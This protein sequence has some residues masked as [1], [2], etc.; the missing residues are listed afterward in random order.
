MAQFLVA[1]AGH[2][3]LCAAMHLARA[4]EH[5]TVVERQPEAALGHDWMD[6][7]EF[8]VLARNGF[9][10]LPESGKV[11]PW[12]NTLYGP[13]KRWPKLPPEEPVTMEACFER[14]ELL[15]GMVADCRAAG[16]EFAFGTEIMAP[17]VRGDAV[18]GLLVREGGAQKELPAGMVVDAAGGL[19]NLREKM[20]E[21]LL[22]PVR[23]KPTQLFHVWRGYLERLPGPAPQYP[24]KTILGHQGRK[25]ISWV[26]AYRDSMDVLI[27]QVGEPLARGVIDEA[28]EDLRTFEPLLGRKLLRGGCAAIPLRRPLGMMVANG[29]AAVGDSA[30]MADP[31]CGSGICSA[32]DQGKLLAEVLLEHC[33]G[34][35]RVDKL[36]SYQYRTFSE[37]P[38]ALAGFGAKDAKERAASEMLTGAVLPLRPKQVDVMFKRGI[39]SIDNID[40]P[41]VAMA[42]LGRNLDHLPLLLKLAGAA[43][44]GGKL[45]AIIGNIPKEYEARAVAAWVRAY[46]GFGGGI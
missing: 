37:K 33:K 3:G 11:Q 15:A 19:S 10:A 34:D 26:I 16:V 7:F 45:G 35:F 40:G 41:K 24:Y 4:G 30:C 5:V 22:F 6:V 32:I 18:C 23:L 9:R 17:L 42:L 43:A 1:G 12:N 25:G 31:F 20:P 38:P 2:G 13:G 44:K 29:Y 39:I 14:R 36:W 27:G 8:G 46:E 28:L 21:E